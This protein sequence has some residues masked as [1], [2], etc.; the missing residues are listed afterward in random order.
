MKS[1]GKG[2]HD[3]SRPAH[4]PRVVAW[5]GSVLLLCCGVPGLKAKVGNYANLSTASVTLITLVYWH[6]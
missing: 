4:R 2:C 3:R 1:H 5:Y 6:S